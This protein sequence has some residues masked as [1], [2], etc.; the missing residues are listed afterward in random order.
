MGFFGGFNRAIIGFP[1]KK[2]TRVDGAKAT[3]MTT[4]AAEQMK[5]AADAAQYLVA[6]KLIGLKRGVTL[7]DAQNI[8]ILNSQLTYYWIEVEFNPSTMRYTAMNGSFQQQQSV[9]GD[10]GSHIAQYNID[11]QTNMSF[12][13][14]IDSSICLSSTT[15]FSASTVVSAAANLYK[16][17]DYYN[18]APIVDGFCSLCNDVETQYIIFAWGKM[19][20]WGVLEEVNAEYVMFD[21]DG[22]PIRAKISMS[23]RQSAKINK[24]D[25]HE[26]TASESNKYWDNVYKKF[27]GKG[28]KNIQLGSTLTYSSMKD[29]NN[30]LNLK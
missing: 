17:R 21:T 6:S 12:E 18:I 28:D 22:K 14:Y 19:I 13:I 4:E 24:D 11:A 15:G 29:F 16:G 9:T 3:T 1:R 26:G 30:L 10:I 27:F 23:I 20:F 7:S 5:K 25:T 8:Q 2:I